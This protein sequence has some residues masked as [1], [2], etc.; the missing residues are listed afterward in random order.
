MELFP[1]QVEIVSEK[2]RSD[3]H[4]QR[5]ARVESSLVYLKDIIGNRTRPVKD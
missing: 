4:H 5:K 3:N 1:F 2:Y